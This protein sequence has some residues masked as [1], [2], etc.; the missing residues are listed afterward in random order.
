MP[1]LIDVVQVSALTAVAV[2]Y[3]VIIG[4]VAL[5]MVYTMS[6]EERNIYS[7]CKARRKRIIKILK[8]SH[9]ISEDAKSTLLSE[10]DQINL[11]MAAIG[12][13]NKS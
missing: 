3:V 1:K 10:L 13:N 5:A 6:P 7:R 2:I 9:Y 8:D 4:A 11:E 12:K